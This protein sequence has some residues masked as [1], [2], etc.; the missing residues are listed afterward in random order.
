MITEHWHDP[1]FLADAAYSRASACLRRRVKRKDFLAVINSVMAGQTLFPLEILAQAFE[2][3]N[4]T[5]RE[6]EVL[7]L[8]AEGKRDREIAEMLVTSF[9]TIRNHVRHILKKLDVHDRKEAVRRARRR[10]LI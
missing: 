10:G 2:P 8:M 3:I 6:R 9:Y 1:L 4:L 7:K 5:P